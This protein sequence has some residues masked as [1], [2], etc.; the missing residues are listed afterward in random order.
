MI[1]RQANEI[2]LKEIEFYFLNKYGPLYVLDGIICPEKFY[3][4]S[5]RILWI[6]K[7]ANVLRPEQMRPDFSDLREGLSEVSVC[8]QLKGFAKTYTKI[9]LASYEILKKS[10]KSLPCSCQEILSRIAVINVKKQAGTKRVTGTEIH[11]FYKAD[12]ELLHKQIET[13]SPDI[14]I[15]ASRN[16]D[17]FF[18]PIGR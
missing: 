7:D 4:T 12:K 2:K 18:C 8:N 17:L 1:N 11:A 14:I 9:V 5:S 6:L 10:E 15:N 3:Q 13:I 16:T